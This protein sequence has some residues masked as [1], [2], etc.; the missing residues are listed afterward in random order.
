MSINVSASKSKTEIFKE[1]ESQ[2]SS[3]VRIRYKDDTR[4]WGGFL[5]IDEEDAEKFI[6]VFFPHL[7]KDILSISGK[8]SPKILIV[9]PQKRLS[10]QYHHRRA[11]IWKLIGG[12]AGVVTSDNDTEKETRH[13]NINDIVELKQGER[14]RLIGL[15]NWGVLAE[16]WRHTD[17]QHPSDEDD[18]VRVQD[19]FGR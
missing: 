3:Y 18:I 7:T 14:H 1:I 5:V 8:L 6:Q 9:A 12:E 11:E 19:D 4:P 15:N 10:W 13:L 2:I 17:A 16:I